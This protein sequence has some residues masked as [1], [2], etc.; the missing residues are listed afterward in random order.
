[1][2]EAVVAIKRIGDPVTQEA[3]SSAVR[4]AASL[5]LEGEN[6]LRG[7]KV[8]IKPNIFCPMPAPVTTD[9]RV[10]AALVSYA[11]ECGASEA[12]VA[13]GR[14]ISTAKYRKT[15]NTTRAC[16]EVLGI[17]KA[18]E[19]AGG[20]MVFFEEDEFVEVPVPGGRVLKKVRVPRTVLD[21]E[22]FINNPVLKIHSLTLVTLGI[23]NLH[24]AISDEDKLFGHSYR[25]LP[26]KLTDFLRV[27]KPDL[28]VIDGITGLEGDHADEGTPVEM[29]IIIAGR[30]V[31]AVDA[32]ASAVMGFEPSEIDT[33]AL[34]HEFGLGQGSLS[35]I[36]VAGDSIE[37]VRRPFARPDIVLDASMF[38]GLEI[39]AGDYCRSCQYYIRRG[40]DKLADAGA[41]SPD[42]KVT[43]ILGK[44]PKVPD[45]L[46]GKVFMLGDCCLSSDSIRRLRDHLLLDGRSEMVFA[47]PPMQFRIRALEMMGD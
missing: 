21:A 36:R 46:P 34:A 22:V 45:R 1:L 32:V 18:V 16:A 47:C 19:S 29:G 11:L 4:K 9:P 42:K 17:T 15:N 23:K 7:K 12:I 24:G 2:E 38:P 10:T 35:A 27:R 31:V 41:F 6:T 33:T 3:V 30:D 39:I 20:R 40:L 14:S 5:V 25:E 28:T 44:E 43:I 26:A 13:E 8:V 37:R